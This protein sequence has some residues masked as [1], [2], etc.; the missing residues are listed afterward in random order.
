MT[1]L[2]PSSV[3]EV[4]ALIGEARHSG[5]PLWFTGSGS[6]PIPDQH[7]IVSTRGL[8][9]IVDYKPDDL[10]VVVRCGTTLGELDGELKENSHTAV[11]PETAPER[12]V[13]GA[14]ASGASGYR[15]LRYGPTRDRVIGIRFATGYGE[16]VS[17]GGQLVKN[18][19]GYDIPRLMTGSHGALGFMSEISLKLWPVAYAPRTVQV[20]DPASLRTGLYRPV[21]ALETESGGFVY[22]TGPRDPLIE[23]SATAGHVWPNQLEEA[24]IV[25]VNVPARLVIEAIGRIRDLGAERFVAQHGVGVVEV[26]WSEVGES[27]ILDLRSWVESHGGS[28]VLARRG[29]LDHTVSRWGAAPQT[30]QIQ[31]RLK[32]LFDPDGV[33][34]PGVLSGGV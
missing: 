1:V 5:Q 23:G 22:V 25:A 32:S 18:V 15:R 11:L 19:T 10:T 30:I 4:K 26:G 34:N 7:T 13:G 21:A 14:V 20:E 29:P 3:S 17:A 8:S 24:V 28:L 2:V 33:C 16:V 9:G 27:Q 6:A 31:R 12:T